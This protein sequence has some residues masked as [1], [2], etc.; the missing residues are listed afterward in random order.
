M[1]DGGT[2]ESKIKLIL[3]SGWCVACVAVK[4]HTEILS[5]PDSKIIA[6][7]FVF[8]HSGLLV[9][10][11]EQREHSCK[12]QRTSSILYSFFFFVT[13]LSCCDLSA[14]LRASARCCDGQFCHPRRVGGGEMDGWMGAGGHTRSRAFRGFSGL[15]Q[16]SSHASDV[17]Y[18]FF[19]RSIFLSFLLFLVDC[20]LT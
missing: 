6:F 8:S 5:I 11:A 18:P 15:I 9:N 1:K 2:F 17:G 10:P 12:Q 3:K 16:I 14:A 13:F 4:Q 7:G 20:I 19:F